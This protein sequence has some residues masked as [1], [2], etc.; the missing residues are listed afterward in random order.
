MKSVLMKNE[1]FEYKV[2]NRGNVIYYLE[3]WKKYK[4][5]ECWDEKREH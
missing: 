2:I 3:C 5:S 1:L 4:I